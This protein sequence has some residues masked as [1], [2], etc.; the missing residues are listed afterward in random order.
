MHAPRPVGESEAQ[1]YNGLR[2]GRGQSGGTHGTGIALEVG[3]TAL[4]GARPELVATSSLRF[5]GGRTVSV[6]PGRRW[7]FFP[8]PAF[9]ERHA[10]WTF[11]RRI[12][13]GALALT[14]LGA[15]VPAADA[16]QIVNPIFQVPFGV[17]PYQRV[18]PGLTALQANFLIASRGQAL[19]SVPPYAL[20]FN[21]YPS[22]IYSPYANPLISGGG[23]GNP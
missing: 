18:R 9:S 2:R 8:N 12:A 1:G 14:I 21:P 11:T 20:G 6:Y 7:A 13:T 16:Q 19:S 4:Q 5:V 23:Y 3:P 10:M 22:P 17:N 15:A